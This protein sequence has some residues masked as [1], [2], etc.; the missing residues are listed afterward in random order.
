MRLH[1]GA[2]YHPQ[3]DGETGSCC[4]AGGAAEAN[5]TLQYGRSRTAIRKAVQAPEWRWRIARSRF[6]AGAAREKTDYSLRKM[7]SG[8]WAKR[9]LL[10]D[11][12]Y[13]TIEKK[14]QSDKIN[15]VEYNNNSY[16]DDP[17]AV[18]RPTNLRAN[19]AP[20]ATKIVFNVLN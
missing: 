13:E 11:M 4:S 16:G 8:H 18:L 1:S 19:M 17:V 3:R 5:G 20:D 12:S 15:I 7:S 9:C 10:K 14:G 2:G 6:I